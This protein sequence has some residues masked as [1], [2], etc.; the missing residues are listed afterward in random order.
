[1][2]NDYRETAMNGTAFGQANA[3][4]VSHEAR[5]AKAKLAADRYP[6]LFST[7]IFVSNGNHAGQ[8]AVP[9][10]RLYQHSL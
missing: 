4:K 6:A 7:T 2:K 5:L 8:P 9:S 10:M 1:M 3:V